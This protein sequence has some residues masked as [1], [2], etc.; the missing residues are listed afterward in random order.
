MHIR[1]HNLPGNLGRK[2]QMYLH[3]ATKNDYLSGN[4]QYKGLLFV[5]EFACSSGPPGFLPFSPVSSLK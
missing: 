5:Y 2:S 4:P 1:L 3:A